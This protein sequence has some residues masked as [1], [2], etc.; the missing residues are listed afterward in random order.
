MLISE[1]KSA[2]YDASLEQKVGVTLTANPTYVNRLP[3]GLE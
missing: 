3:R 2:I 1:A